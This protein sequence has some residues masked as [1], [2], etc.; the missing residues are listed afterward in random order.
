MRTVGQYL[1]YLVVRIVICVAQ[2]VPLSVCDRASATLAW[3]FADVLGVRRKVTDENLRHAFPEWSA[4]ERRRVARRM[5]QHLFLFV[6]EVAQ[7]ARKIR[8]ESW[9]QFVKLDGEEEIVRLLMSGR[10]LL[11]VTAHFGNFELAGFVFSLFG[12]KIH[13][14]ARPL[15]NP[16]LDRFLHRFRASAGQEMLSKQDDYARIRDILGEGGTVSFLADQYA[17][18][19][20]SWV[21]FFGR[22]ASAHKAIPL[23]A[24]DNDAPIVVGCC[25]RVAGRPLHYELKLQAIA[26]PR[27]L[28]PKDATVTALAQWYHEQ[29]EL[30]IREAPEQ[31]WWLHR[32]WKDKREKRRRERD[33]RRAQ[34]LGK[35][36]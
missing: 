24:L 22:P 15:D 3:L 29:F 5:W 26:D 33:A 10:P 36:A 20:G 30:M 28:A 25:R 6:C 27:E 4:A 12:Y 16:F 1:V 21:E 32:R 18:I 13:T 23:F 2:A 31:Y 14:V 9:H 35:A 7:T 17:G 8:P 11:L 34:Q 19:K